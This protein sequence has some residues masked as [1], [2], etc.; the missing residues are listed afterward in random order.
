MCAESSPRAARS[1][2]SDETPT[3]S[4]APT[5]DAPSP[6][7]PPDAPA[8]EPVTEPVATDEPDPEP[9]TEAADEAPTEA[10]PGDPAPADAEAPAAAG[11]PAA[12]S[13]R[14]DRGRGVFVPAWIAVVAG[15]L[16]VAGLGFL[17]GWIAA[18]NDDVSPSNAAATAPDTGADDDSG[19]SDD[20]GQPTRPDGSDDDAGLPP[21]FRGAYLGVGI[22]TAENGAGVMITSVE[23][24]SPADDAGLEE[25]D[26]VTAVDGIEVTGALDLV[27]Q[28]RGHDVGD[29]VTVTYTRDGASADTEV[30][31]ATRPQ[32]QSVS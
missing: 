27:R 8:D 22:D 18:P 25:G 6:D 12:A 13:A 9:P 3:E 15:V 30:T 7:A 31:L 26:V 24:G 23:P 2:V 4:D 20:S 1:A 28:V 5:G 21:R 29:E 16:L 17:I 11:V 32:S 14:G 19:G 10:A